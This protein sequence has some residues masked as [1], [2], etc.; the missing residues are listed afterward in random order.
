MKTKISIKT[1]LFILVF[2]ALI[3]FTNKVQAKSYEIKNM[4]IQAT[5]E[6]NGSVSIKQEMTYK[7]NGE[8]NGIYID[9]PDQVNDIEY[10]T[11]RVQTTLKDSLY[12]ASNVIIN[13]VLIENREAAKVF[14]AYNG[15]NNVYVESAANNMRRIKIY[16]PSV[17]TEKKFTLEYTLTNLCVK[18]NDIGELYYNFIGGGWETTIG[19]LNIDIYLPNNESSKKE[20]YVFG[21]GPY[22][23]DC[24]IISNKKFNFTVSNIKPGQYVAARVLFPT[25]NIQNSTKKSNLNAL[26]LV[27]QDENNIIENKIEKERFTYKVAIFA[28]VLFIYWIILLLIFEKDKKYSSINIDDEE[29]FKKYNPLLAGC[30]QESRTILAR[31]II[32]VIINLINKNIV[33]LKLV[34]V[35]S[36]KETYTYVLTQIPETESKMDDIERFVYNWVFNSPTIDLVE[37]LKRLPKEKEANKKF[38]ELNNKAQDKLKSIGANKEMPLGIKIF[39]T[40][41]FAISI[42]VI[43]IHIR[44]NVFNIYSFE[45]IGAELK[46]YILFGLALFPLLMAII[47][48][49]IRILIMI[50]HGVNRLTKKITGKRIVNTTITIV[51]IFAIIIIATTII[52]PNSFFIVDELL[53]AI[54]L[55]IILTDNLMLKN[56]PV[57]IEDF[58]KLNVLKDKL[59]NTLMDSRDVEYVELWNQY[60]AYAISFGIADKIISKLKGLNLDDDLM[61]LVENNNFYE[62]ISSDYHTFYVYASLDRMF[63]KQYEKALGNMVKGLGSGYSSRKWRR[64]FWWRRLFRRWRP[65]RPEE[66]PS[67][68]E[69]NYELTINLWTSWNW[70]KSVLL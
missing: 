70:K 22:N 31:D 44:F 23:G 54:A 32:A 59:E 10:D 34:P 43:C 61:K 48:I 12:N 13:K 52:A 5:V 38:K 21:H 35:P 26:S 42:I 4:D 66:E 18:H 33:E 27:L 62:Y 55:I 14:S 1:I 20:L 50:R 9:I 69:L 56:S 41:L 28:G 46:A 57:M 58:S 6:K 60:L 67:K 2:T 16:S 17:N 19:N 51:I 53:I 47:Y 68:K 49:P 8:Y 63:I 45:N 15:D 36:G 37:R 40:F 24:K 64:I 3:I 29:L 11:Y 30:I 65:R 39:N 7:F 25:S